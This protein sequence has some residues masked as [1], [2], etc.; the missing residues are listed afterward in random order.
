M[1]NEIREGIQHLIELAYETGYISAQMEA[2]PPAIDAPE[3][4]AQKKL[5]ETRNRV[6]I[7]LLGL[8]DEYARVKAG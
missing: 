2:N 7:Q 3:R 8:I 1:E 5:I 6:K 4:E